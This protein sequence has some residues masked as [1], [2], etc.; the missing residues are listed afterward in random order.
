MSIADAMANW[1]AS[2]YQSG[3]DLLARS[4][5]SDADFSFFIKNDVGHE[6]H[7]FA[8]PADFASYDLN[9]WS[10]GSNL[11]N[12]ENRREFLQTVVELCHPS[13]Y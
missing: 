13:L 7:P 6:A 9:S 12:Q 2:T 5:I 1:A 8:R 3:L 11:P 4:E 10:A